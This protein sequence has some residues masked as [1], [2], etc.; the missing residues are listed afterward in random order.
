MG[1]RHTERPLVRGVDFQ[2]H[3]ENPAD[4]LADSRISKLWIKRIS[5]GVNVYSWDRGEAVPAADDVATCLVDYLAA[6]LDQFVEAMQSKD[7]E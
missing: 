6:G 1:F 4:E 5:D 3:S 2:N 7:G